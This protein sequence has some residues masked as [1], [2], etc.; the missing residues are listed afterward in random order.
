MK[1][2]LIITGA[3]GRMGKRLIALGIES[4]D[5]VIIGAVERQNHP[6]IGKDAGV[7][8]VDS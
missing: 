5:F 6:D 1:P 8:A 2:K 7:L 3:G 4:G